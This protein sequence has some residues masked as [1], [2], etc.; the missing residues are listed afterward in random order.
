M[1]AV[2]AVDL[3]ATSGRVILGYVDG[4]GLRLEHV[5]RFPNIP[6]ATADGLHWN[7]LE[8]FSSVQKGLVAATNM[9]P[10]AISV[11]STVGAW[12][13]GFCAGAGF[14]E[15]PITTETTEPYAQ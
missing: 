14:S 15:S 13:T 3:G 5:A 4:K 1:T 7:T 8:L 11:E 9:E 12:T 2:I 10:E 6:V